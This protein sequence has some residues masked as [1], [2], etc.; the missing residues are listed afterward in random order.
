MN[1]L[2]PGIDGPHL[3]DMVVFLRTILL[4]LCTE[5]RSNSLHP[6]RKSRPL[7]KL[8]TALYAESRGDFA[9]RR[10]TY[11]LRKLLARPMC[12]I[13]R[14]SKPTLSYAT[15][16]IEYVLYSIHLERDAQVGEIV[17]CGQ[18]VYGE[19]HAFAFAFAVCNERVPFQWLVKSCDF[20][21]KGIIGTVRSFQ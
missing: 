19:R 18:A 1:K 16:C 11:D 3:C 6:D 8:S 14:H 5:H 12:A 20:T 21:D 13:N 2:C 9:G 4:I 17:W 7:L 15:S 10:N